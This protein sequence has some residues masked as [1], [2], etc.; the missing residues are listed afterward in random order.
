M[1]ETLL[2]NDSTF[3]MEAFKKLIEEE[4][5]EFYEIANEVYNEYVDAVS[6]YGA[7]ASAHEGYAIIK[8]EL[9]ELWDEI[10]EKPEYTNKENL[11]KEALQLAAMAIR[12]V[13]DIT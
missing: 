4:R 11:R 6:E 7:F 5:K 3:F 8:E 2:D 1:A 12:F 10:K 9:E 13:K